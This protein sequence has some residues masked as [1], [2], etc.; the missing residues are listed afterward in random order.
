VGAPF[1]DVDDHAAIGF[2]GLVWSAAFGL[3]VLAYGPLL[4]RPGEGRL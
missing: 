4:L 1:L 3:F 2:G